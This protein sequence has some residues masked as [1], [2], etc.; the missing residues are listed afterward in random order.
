MRQH[1]SNWWTSELTLLLFYCVAQLRY[2][3]SIPSW[4]HVTTSFQVAQQAGSAPPSMSVFSCS[5]LCMKGRMKR[6]ARL[7][8]WRDSKRAGWRAGNSRSGDSGEL[9]GEVSCP[10]RTRV[11]PSTQESIVEAMPAGGAHVHTSRSKNGAGVRIRSQVGRLARA[12]QAIKCS[13]GQCVCACA[14]ASI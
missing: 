9:S 10:V 2:F 8:A 6:Q 7:G 4:R 13:A 1:C 11:G 5:L 14:R 12:S 3:P